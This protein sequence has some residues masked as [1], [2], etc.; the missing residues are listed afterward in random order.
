MST[1]TEVN[2]LVINRLTKA[3]FDA[4]KQAGT[5]SSTEMYMV[6]DYESDGVAWGS[7]TGTLSDQ[8]D[9]IN[10]LNSKSGVIIRRYS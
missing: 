10:A 3:Q 1:D 9:L 7:I 5:L 8:T 4:A 6:S 2:E